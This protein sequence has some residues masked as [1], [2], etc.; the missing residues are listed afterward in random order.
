M[1]IHRTRRAVT[2]RALAGMFLCLLLTTPA[3]ASM[4]EAM[5]AY[6]QRDYAAALQGFQQ[7]AEQGDS[8]AQYSLGLMY[9]YGQGVPQDYAEALAWYK[10]AGERGDAKALY[11]VARMYNEGMGVARDYVEAFDW[12]KKAAELGNGDAQTQLGVIYYVGMQIPRDYVKSL[13]W[14]N[15][16]ASLGVDIAP[17]YAGVVA[18]HMTAAQ[19]V[20]AH[21]LADAWLEK[22]LTPQ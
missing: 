10:K 19:I 1:S 5:V 3:G 11:S 8:I 16:A 18:K 7:Y 22:Y 13:K 2:G 15:I 17:K 21:Y 12:F 6:S 4:Y 20:E 14:L 9:F